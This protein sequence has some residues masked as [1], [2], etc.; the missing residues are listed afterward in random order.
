MRRTS[1]R[2]RASP[3]A[4]KGTTY[5]GPVG[6]PVKPK[7]RLP[8]LDPNGAE[9]PDCH[10]MVKINP[11]T[12]TLKAHS[13]GGG[14]VSF[15][16]SWP[17][18]PSSGVHSSYTVKPRPDRLIAYQPI[19]W[20]GTE[21]WVVKTVRYHYDQGWEGRVIESVHVRTD[22]ADGKVTYARC[23]PCRSSS[24]P[25]CKHVRAVLKL[26]RDEHRARRAELSVAG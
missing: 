12:G 3:P 15:E 5:R 13:E 4:I 20:V 17:Q 14:P 1:D 21:W 16:K 7:P 11:G 23:G 10:A 25:G 8:H 26:V 18:C 19:R 24:I 2:R 6:S 22:A 9:C